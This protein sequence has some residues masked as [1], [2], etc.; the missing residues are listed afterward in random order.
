VYRL[1]KFSKDMSELFNAGKAF[2]QRIAEVRH[3]VGRQAKAYGIR[4]KKS[5][6]SPLA[7]EFKRH[8]CIETLFI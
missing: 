4:R 5:Q 6:R 1:V 3:A 8:V 7:L 2:C